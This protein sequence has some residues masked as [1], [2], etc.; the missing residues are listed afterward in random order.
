M[1]SGPLGVAAF[2]IP[3][4]WLVLITTKARGTLRRVDSVHVTFASAKRRLESMARGA[5]E[6]PTIQAMN[7]WPND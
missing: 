7:V 4:V 1:K 3:N 5:D 6:L 2:D